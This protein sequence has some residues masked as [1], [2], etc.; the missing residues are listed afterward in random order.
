MVDEEGRIIGQ[1]PARQTDYQRLRRGYV[2]IPQQTAFFRS[3]LWRQVGPL[4][5][6][7]YFAMD[8]DLWVRLAKIAPLRYHPRTW[9]NFRLHGGAKSL[10][11]D[12]RCWPEMVRVHRREGGSWF[13]WLVFKATV[14]PYI[15][16]WLPWRFRTWLRG[17]LLFAAAMTLGCP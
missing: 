5:P 15:Y 8:Y 3:A 9:A 16:A 13:S 7:F 6:S 12:E 11:A 1:F 10:V 2:H 14:R 17:L 4:D